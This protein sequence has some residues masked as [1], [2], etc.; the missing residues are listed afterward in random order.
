MAEQNHDRFGTAEG[1]RKLAIDIALRALI[2][3]ASASDPSLRDRLVAMVD[4]YT[5]ELEPHSNLE[6]DFATRAKANMAAL[7]QPPH[8]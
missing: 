8:L 4:A 7:I 6:D 5:A 2:D 3:H 1:A